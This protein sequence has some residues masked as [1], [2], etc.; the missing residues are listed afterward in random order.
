MY[1]FGV[2]RHGFRVGMFFCLKVLFTANLQKCLTQ[3][4]LQ[5]GIYADYA[6]EAGQNKRVNI[7][8]FSGGLRRKPE[9]L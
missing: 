3:A 5:A 1:K 9:G 7:S 2:C 8:R 6:M 4:C